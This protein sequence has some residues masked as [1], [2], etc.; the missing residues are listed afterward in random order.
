M[1]NSE[2][3]KNIT[4]L[5]RKYINAL[6]LNVDRN[7][8]PREIDLVFSGGALNGLFGIGVLYYIKALEEQGFTKVKRVSGC[9]IGSLLAVWY[10][11]NCVEDPDVWFTDIIRMFKKKQ[12]NTAYNEKVVKI[13]YNLF[14]DDESVKTL[15][16][17]LFISF[18]DMK[19]GKQKT[20]SNF[21]GRDHL[22]EC[23]ISS[24]YLPRITDGSLRYKERYIDGITPHIFKD[25]VREVLVVEL[26]SIKKLI[27]SFSFKKETN[28]Y[29]RLL[30][31]VADASQFF[32]DGSSDMCKYYKDWSYLDYG[33]YRGKELL[34]Y[35]LVYLVE[36][37]YNFRHY[38]PTQITD[39]T[40]YH[41]ILKVFNNI[42]NDLL[43][44]IIA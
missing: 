2:S 24:S 8:L 35:I 22:I 15:N 27:K 43:F 9:S 18:Y 37:I 39:T 16:D 36:V 7:R 17:C 3:N 32:V 38:I 10:I 20:V 28:T 19:K 4:S 30:A 40:M 31:G 13:V 21:K 6:I 42:Y 34:I 25:S 12:N 33:S 5:M 44:H 23:L 26:M 14:I 41:G 29:F 11:T 1:S